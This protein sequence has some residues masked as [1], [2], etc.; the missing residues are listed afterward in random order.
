[1]AAPRPVLLAALLAA[2]PAQAAPA[3]APAPA[4]D[5]PMLDAFRAVCDKVD[6]LDGMKAAALADGWE[7]IADSAEPRLERLIRMGKEA[8]EADGTNSGHNFRRTVAGRKLLLIA[9]R[10]EDKSGFWGNGCRL[11]D[12]DATAPVN[13]A[14]ARDWIGKVPSG[15]QALGPTIGDKMLWEPGWRDGMTVEIS[16]VPQ[17]SELKERFGLSGNVLV[18]QAIGGF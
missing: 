16:H 4:A 1:M 11:Y 15:V 6:S 3:P 7:E 17:T 14:V 13:S 5:L 8:T 10:Y 2:A 18:A 12:F 9:S